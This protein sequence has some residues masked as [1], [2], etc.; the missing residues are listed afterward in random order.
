M[1]QTVSI[2]QISSI[3]LDYLFGC[4]TNCI[5]SLKFIDKINCIGILIIIDIFNYLIHILE[6]IPEF[7][8]TP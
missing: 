2:T 6:S 7:V 5:D 3:Y 4:L 1:P 8:S